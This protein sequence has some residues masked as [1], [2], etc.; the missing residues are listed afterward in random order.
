MLGEQRIDNLLHP[1]AARTLH[2]QQVA[3]RDQ[4]F[5]KFGGFLRRCEKLRPFA[6][7]ACGYRAFYN[8]R[9]VTGDADDPVHLAG[10]RR[11]LTRFA[12][13]FRRRISEFA[14]LAGDENPPLEI[15]RRREQFRHGLQRRRARVVTVI[16]ERR[17]V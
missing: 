12:V 13:Q 15:G 4:S 17:P 6:R 9:S 3:G 11:E 7:R 10:F 14:H 16:D 1:H 2:Q 8:L 5:Q